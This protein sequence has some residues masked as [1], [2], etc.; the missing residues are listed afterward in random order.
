M[1]PQLILL[2]RVFK[3]GGKGVAYGQLMVATWYTFLVLLALAGTLSV[4][5]F[6]AVCFIPRPLLMPASAAF[7]GLTAL[8]HCA[9][10]VGD[11]HDESQV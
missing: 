10:H 1:A 8:L 7:R 3:A 6:K 2:G 5:D 11:G 4:W 9:G